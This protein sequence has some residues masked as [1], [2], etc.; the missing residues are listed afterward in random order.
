M[1]DKDS[2]NLAVS[3]NLGDGVTRTYSSALSYDEAGR[4]KEEKYG[5]LTP[6]YHKQHFN[7][8]GQLYDIRL[9][10]VPLATD[11]WNWNR[12]AITNSYDS[13]MTHQDPNS[14]PDNNGNL[15]RS[16]TWVPSDDQISGYNW[17][18]QNYGYDY[19]NRLTSVAE[20]QNGSTNAYAQAYLYDRWGNRTINIQN[21]ATWGYGINAVQTV[22]DANANRMYAPND[23]NHTLVDYDVAGNQTRGYLT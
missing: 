8:R 22:A 21:N 19:L 5:T 3:G 11:Q 18:Q 7:I 6:L 15:L 1:G 17:T 16:E 23:P 20:L 2:Q 13:R 9:S 12:G 10:T 14:S 4:M